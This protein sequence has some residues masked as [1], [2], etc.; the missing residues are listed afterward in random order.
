VQRE[1][2]IKHVLRKY[3]QSYKWGNKEP[4]NDGRKKIYFSNGQ[5]GKRTEGQ[6]KRQ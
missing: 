5:K 3:E 4:S 6:M 2:G 1:R